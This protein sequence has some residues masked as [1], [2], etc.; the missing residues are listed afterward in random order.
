MFDDRMVKPKLYEIIKLHKPQ[1]RTYEIDKIAKDFGHC[2]I[3]LPPYHCEFNP[4][5][6]IC[7]QVKDFV[8]KRNTKFTM[9]H[10]LQVFQDGV[11][12]ITAERFLWKGRKN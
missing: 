4:I 9:G 10:L 11:N 12:S 3:R 5:E 2:V 1:F 6:L 8:R 7:A